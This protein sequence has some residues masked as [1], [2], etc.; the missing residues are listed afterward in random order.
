MHKIMVTVEMPVER[1]GKIAIRALSLC[2]ARDVCFKRSGDAGRKFSSRHKDFAR[3]WF[4]S[5][6]RYLRMKRS[7]DPTHD[8]FAGLSCLTPW[9]HGIQSMLRLL[10]PDQRSSR[11]ISY[12]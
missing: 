8:H 12:A 6:R 9:K 2:A 11:R 5:Q 7:R 10:D 3:I 4:G 1:S